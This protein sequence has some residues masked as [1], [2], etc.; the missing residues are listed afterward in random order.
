MA[1]DRDRTIK[2]TRERRRHGVV[3]PTREQLADARGDIGHPFRAVNILE[4]WRATGKI[5]LEQVTA[6]ERYADDVSLAG[7]IGL[8]AA[9]LEAVGQGAGD[10]TAAQ[11]DARRRWWAATRALGGIGS[12]MEQMTWHCLGHGLQ[13][14]ETLARGHMP[15]W[16]NPSVATGLLIAA[17]GVLAAHY[18]LTEGRRESFS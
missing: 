7:L 12:P 4:L 10:L 2:P 18:G 3:L 15:R 16:V 9:P 8:R 5:G 17:V 14:T 1:S 11:I 6:G 13:I